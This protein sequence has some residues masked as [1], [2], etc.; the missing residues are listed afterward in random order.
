MVGINQML[1]EF[2]QEH[3]DDITEEWLS[4]RVETKGSVYS[5]SAGEKTEKSLREQNR[6]TNLTIASS[7]LEDK[8][9]FE[10]NKKNWALLVAQSRIHTRTPIYEVQEALGKVR[11]AYWSWIE[12]FVEQNGEKVLRT[13]ILNWG[14]A[15]HMAFD[16]LM[17]EFSKRYDELMNTRL[18]AQQML[19]EELNAPIIKLN[20]TIGVLPII[21]DIDTTRVQSIADYVPQKSVEL[22]ISHLFIDLSGVSLIDTMVA[23]HLYQMTQMLDLL[24]IQS[25]LTGIRPEI[26]QTS[27]Q[28]GLDFSRISTYGSLQ[29]ALRKN[30]AT[31]G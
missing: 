10:E 6:L 4:L 31:I 3:I 18:S 29:L 21:G 1:Y 15:I 11:L 7:L 28:L 12:N 9:I 23:N 16:A 13:D 24:G 22:G 20:G 2:L 5:I 25:S 27:V 14:I 26:A 8:E 19:I 30:L 17:V